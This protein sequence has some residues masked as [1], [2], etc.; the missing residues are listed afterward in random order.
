MD[1]TVPLRFSGYSGMDIGRD[2]G[3]VVDRDYAD[4]APFAFTGT[5]KK[6]IFDIK[7]HLTCRGRG[8]C[9]NRRTTGTWPTASADS[10]H[11]PVAASRTIG[12]GRRLADHGKRAA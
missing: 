9:T 8:R 6:V 10:L 11:C 5:I 1:F 2:N 3:G 7:P 4:Q 12:S